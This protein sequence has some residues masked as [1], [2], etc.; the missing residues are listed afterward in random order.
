MFKT[1]LDHVI[2][3]EKEMNAPTSH[4]LFVHMSRQQVE[5]T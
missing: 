1:Y 3:L 4:R 5:G 2:V